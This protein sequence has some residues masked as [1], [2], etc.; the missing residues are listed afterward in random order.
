MKDPSPDYR[1][2]AVAR[3]WNVIHFFYPYKH[4]I[5]DWNAVLPESIA[6]MEAS[7]RGARGYAL[8]L[9]K[10]AAHVA[11]GHTGLYGLPELDQFYGESWLPIGARWIDGACVVT[12]VTDDPAV[13]ASGIAAGDGPLA[14][15]G[16][17]ISPSRAISLIH[18]PG[19]I[20]ELSEPASRALCANS[21]LKPT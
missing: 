15:V 18:W 9:A 2:L 11:D 12:A 4:L 10:M 20:E 16:S 21:G 7:S 3:M 17:G 13:K 8:A 6:A 14:T 19:V 5:G 1:L